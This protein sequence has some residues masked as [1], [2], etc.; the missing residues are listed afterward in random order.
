MTRVHPTALVDAKAELA[1]DVS[2]G[3][4]SSVGPKVTI[5][6]RS[7][8][9][10]HCVITG[11]TRIGRDNHIFQF[12]SVG[13]IPQDKK[14]QGE[15]TL[16]EI[17]DRNTIREGCTINIGTAQ[18]LGKTVIGNNNWIMAYVHIAHDCVLGNQI[19]IAN[20]TGLAGHVVLEDWVV[21][22]GQSGIYQRVRMGAH[23]MCGFQ[24]HVGQAVPPFITAGGNPFRALMVNQEGLKR[25]G[26]SADRIAHIK[27]IYRILYREQRSLTDAM[28]TIKTMPSSSGNDADKKA[29]LAFLTHQHGLGLGIVR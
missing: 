26:F 2:V 28:Q 19:I 10:S 23:S 7:C 12:A 9:A 13:E 21:V 24:S 14:Y 5:G 8:I 1:D 4:Y 3:A 18:D 20:Y 29:M 27:Q 16:L 15:D 11:N 22:G 6:A 25:R 17:G